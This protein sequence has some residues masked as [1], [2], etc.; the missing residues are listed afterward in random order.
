MDFVTVGN[1]N[2]TFISVVT[3]KNWPK[4]HFV[5]FSPNPKFWCSATDPNSGTAHTL[6]GHLKK[7]IRKVLPVTNLLPY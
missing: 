5:C 4:H 2:G 3:Q 7:I 6:G 1:Y